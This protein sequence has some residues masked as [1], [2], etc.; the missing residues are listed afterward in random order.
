MTQ[1]LPPPRKIPVVPRP[2]HGEL[3]GSYL[4]RVARANRTDLRSFLTLLGSLPPALSSES[5]DLAVMVLTL[6]EAAFTRLLAYTGLDGE[7]LI[8][9]IPS[10]APRAISPLGEP[11]AI[12][13]SFV[14]TLATD[15]PGCRL[16]RDGAHADTRLLSPKTACLRHG[17]WLFG[18]G[19]GQRLNLA[20]IPEVAAAQRRLERVASHRGPTAAMRAY[21]IA[22]SYLQH[23]W[24][25]DSHPLW[26]P[27]LVER[28][29]RRVRT[30]GATSARTTWQLPGWA[31]HPECTSVA[32]VFASPYWAA[33]AV[34][35]PDRRHRLFYQ[36]LLA[37]LA[38]GDAPLRTMRT[39]DPLPRDIQEQARWGRLLND[40]DWGAPPPAT[41]TAKAVP[42][43][44][45]TDNYERSIR[46]LANSAAAATANKMT[47]YNS[48]TI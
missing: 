2:R 41:T 23:S 20:A 27:D 44:D 17:Y 8:R 12:R 28:W 34:P 43:V 11:P 37:E 9:A 15:C 47:F 5:P 38:V 25:I 3:S 10:L 30:A 36:R 48:D 46:L 35:A 1:A 42:F 4:A 29:Y 33:L 13:L 31:I 24:R 26:Y 21:E 7:Q 45:I 22:S 39:F 32:A 6:N 40:P 18:Q 19:G 16:R 14:K